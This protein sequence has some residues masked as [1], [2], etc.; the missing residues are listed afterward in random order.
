MS[1]S[2]QLFFPGLLLCSIFN[3]AESDVIPVARMTV[4]MVPSRWDPECS[5]CPRNNARELRPCRTMRGEIWRHQR[6]RQVVPDLVCSASTAAWHGRSMGQDWQLSTDAIYGQRAN[7][8]L[9]SS[10]LWAALVPPSMAGR[11]CDG[12]VRAGH[13][14]SLHFGR[15]LQRSCPSPRSRLCG[16][17]RREDLVRV[18]RCAHLDPTAHH[19]LHFEGS[20]FPAALLFGSCWS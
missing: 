13:R 17:C 4:E 9:L 5:S 3:R 18:L 14:S 8:R 11:V 12:N 1:S 7:A 10:W 16:T 15:R 2:L 20:F 19:H 6:R